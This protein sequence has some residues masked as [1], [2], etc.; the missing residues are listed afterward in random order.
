[1]NLITDYS[2]LRF[3]KNDFSKAMQ[4]DSLRISDIYSNGLIAYRTTDIIVQTSNVD[5]VIGIN[6]TGNLKAELVNCN[7]EVRKDITDKFY[8]NQFI[9]ENGIRQISFEI[10]PIGEDFYNECLFLKLSHTTSD[11]RWYSNGFWVTDLKGHNYIT[12]LF[13]YK[14]N[15]DFVMQSVRL[16]CIDIDTELEQEQSNY[17]D[18][19]GFDNTFRPVDTNY[20]KFIIEKCN[21][22]VYER[23]RNLLKSDIVYINGFRLSNTPSLEKGDRQGTSN[24]FTVEFKG[25]LINEKYNTEFQLYE[26]LKVVSSNPIMPLIGGRTQVNQGL[27]SSIFIFFNKEIEVLPGFKIQHYKDGNL[28]REETGYITEPTGIGLDGLYEPL[29][30][31]GGIE[32]M[33]EV[34][35]H[36]IKLTPNTIKGVGIEEYYPEEGQIVFEWT[37]LQG[38]WDKNDWDNNDWLTN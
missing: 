14:N 33:L 37:V 24:F 28:L 17:I 38:D 29:L 21:R 18:T 23:F 35:I 31:N 22:F 20:F 32:L 5:D 25:N 1:M 26:K 3:V 15:T 4:T 27:Q 19:D 10:L 2:F 8:L 6:F 30:N 7:E 12:Q 36:T 13:E 34:G 11:N 16:K 9:D